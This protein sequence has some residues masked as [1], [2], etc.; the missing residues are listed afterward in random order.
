MSFTKYRYMQAIVFVGGAV[1]GVTIVGFVLVIGASIGGYAAGW[2]AAAAGAPLFEL[3]CARSGDANS[4]S[5]GFQDHLSDPG[6][7][8]KIVADDYR[9]FLTTGR[10][11]RVATGPAPYSDPFNQ[12]S[13]KNPRAPLNE[14][15]FGQNNDTYDDLAPFWGDDIVGRWFSYIGR[16]AGTNADERYQAGL[17][18]GVVSILTFLGGADINAVI[19]VASYFFVI[20]V[21]GI[22]ATKIIERLISRLFQKRTD[23]GRHHVE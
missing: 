7:L 16:I 9:S 1:A 5:K 15:C 23:D 11:R 18:D 14:A 4:S 2:F 3:T 13:D 8:R 20:F 6:E 12:C 22:C 21:L 17:T 10:C 19:Y